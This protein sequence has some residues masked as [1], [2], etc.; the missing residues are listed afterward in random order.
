M[1]CLDSG[2]RAVFQV[3]EQFY[4]ARHRSESESELLLVTRQNDNHSPGPGLGRLV[5]SSHPEK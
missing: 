1:P 2:C 4:D 5:P 3:A